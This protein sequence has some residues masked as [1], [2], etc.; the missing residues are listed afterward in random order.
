MTL[1]RSNGQQSGENISRSVYR[2]YPF[3]AS[4]SS[5]CLILFFFVFCHVQDDVRLFQLSGRALSL[6]CCCAPFRVIGRPPTRIVSTAHASPPSCFTSLTYTG[7]F[8]FPILQLLLP[9]IPYRKKRE[10]EEELGIF[11][12]AFQFGRNQLSFLRCRGL[13]N[14]SATSI[15]YNMLILYEIISTTMRAQSWQKEYKGEFFYARLYELLSVPGRKQVRLTRRDVDCYY[16]G[17]RK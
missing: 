12:D 1:F 14:A 16:G 5:Y 7:F 10:E 17:S 11:V 3:S 2:A 15:L 9:L 13:L 4:F 8:C 6:S